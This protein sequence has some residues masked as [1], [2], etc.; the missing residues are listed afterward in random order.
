LL[1][2]E[3]KGV[4]CKD[5]VGKKLSCKREKLSESVMGSSRKGRGEGKGRD[6]D[7]GSMQVPE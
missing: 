2:W 3:R 7:R 4:K 6:Q 5:A 1:V